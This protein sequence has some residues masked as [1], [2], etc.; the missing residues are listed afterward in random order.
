LKGSPFVSDY[1][2]ITFTAYRD[3]ISVNFFTSMPLKSLIVTSAK[4]FTSSS[5]NVVD[6][7]TTVMPAL[8][9]DNSPLR[10]SSKTTQREFSISNFSAALK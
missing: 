10:E 5:G 7:P 4:A 1:K 2:F 3:K 9:P 6:N 8:L